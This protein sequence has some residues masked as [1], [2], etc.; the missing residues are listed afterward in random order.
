MLRDDAVK[1]GLI[2]PTLGETEKFNLKKRVR[3]PKKE[4][5]MQKEVTEDKKL[6]SDF[7]I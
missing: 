6:D 2:K 5:K 7:F 3:K 1:R 4:T